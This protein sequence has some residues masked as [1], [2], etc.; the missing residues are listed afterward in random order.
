MDTYMPATMS[1][2]KVAIPR[3]TVGKSGEC[4]VRVG[5]VSLR[6]FGW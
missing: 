5:A 2:V 1:A 3:L 6:V 4:G